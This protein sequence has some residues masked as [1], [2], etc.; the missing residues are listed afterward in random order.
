MSEVVDAPVTE[1]PAAAATAAPAVAAAPAAPVFESLI[2]DT[3]APAPAATDPA[4]PAP[5][6][7]PFADLA[8]KLPEKFQVKAG[9]KLDPAASLAKALE[10]RD[11]L[12]KRMG[13]GDLPPKSAAEYAFKMPDGLEEFEF[14]SDKM[15]SFKTEAH[16]LGFTQAQ[17]EFVMARYIDAVPDL[18]EGSAKLSASEARAELQKAWPVSADFEVNISNA[19]RSLRGLPPALQE[20]TREF[21]TNPAFLK[22]M[23][24]MGAQM[25]E[26]S[27]PAGAG[28]PAPAASIDS[29]MAS[30]AYTDPKDP[31]HKM[32]SEQV[33]KHFAG[34][35]GSTP[36]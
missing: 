15:E 29:L 6:A 16:K 28:A 23:A 19:Q 21:G 24:H 32:V 27:P 1:A 30:K 4:A 34:T 36:L 12:E 10:H 9:D 20:A 8:G 26:D 13:S 33:R 25:R 22:V 3:S 2:H 18:M 17:Y 11:H 5:V 35:Y 7:D 14:K 31:S